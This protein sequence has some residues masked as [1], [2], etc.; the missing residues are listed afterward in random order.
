MKAND[1]HCTMSQEVIVRHYDDED[2]EDIV[3]L[4]EDV[5]NGWPHFDLPCKPI[6][7]WR[8]KFQDNPLRLNAVSVAEYNK[9]IIGCSH[10]FY[11]NVKLG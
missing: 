6:D 4:L 3:T 7:H 1:Y 2:V 11:F 8:W 9:K 10:R 5:F